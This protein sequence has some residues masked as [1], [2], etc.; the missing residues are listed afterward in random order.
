MAVMETPPA[1]QENTLSLWHLFR[2]LPYLETLMYSL[3]T[4]GQLFFP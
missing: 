4:L 2:C 1:V 3:N